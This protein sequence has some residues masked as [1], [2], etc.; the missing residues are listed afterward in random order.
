MYMQ[1]NNCFLYM[2][3]YVYLCMYVCAVLNWPVT[4]KWELDDGYLQT[5]E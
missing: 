4:A 5:L 2:C 3:M 1:E